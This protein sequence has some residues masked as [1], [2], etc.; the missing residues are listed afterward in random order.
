M[1]RGEAPKIRVL[2][3][4][5]LPA[6][7]LLVAVSVLWGVFA[8]DRPTHE[9]IT[10][11]VDR[12]DV[13]RRVAAS[14]KLRASNTIKVGAEVSGQIIRVNVDFD[15]AVIAGQVLAEID[16]TRL[17]ARVEQVRAQ[18][19]TSQAA[20]AQA[21]ALASRARTD[22]GLQ[23]REFGRRTA[24]AARGFVSASSLDAASGALAS[25]RVGARTA[26]TQVDSARAGIALA[27]AELRAA[28]LDLRRT[29]IVSPATGVVI[30][31]LV[32]PGTTVVASFQTPNLFEIATDTKRMQIEASVDEADIGQVRVGQPVQFTVDSYPDERFVTAVR[33]IRQAA[34][35]S[36]NVVSYLVILDVDNRDGRL[37]SGMTAD[38]EI[39]TGRKADVPRIPIS[40]LRFRPRKEDR[41][42]G[43]AL[44]PGQPAVYLATRD[45]LRPVRRLVRLGLTGDDFAEVAGGLKVGD[46]VL[47][48][49]RPVKPGKETDSEEDADDAA[50]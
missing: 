10:H 4:L 50:A 3:R 32:D 26:A 1:E 45:P 11:V 49:S 7:L 15:S 24:L 12:G 20:L 29:R 48:R 22:L 27:N 16:P 33:Q 2:R 40:A 46:A 9:Y 14:G 39:I 44:P 19:A 47:V 25:A 42:D 31:R 35:E 37:L 18:V 13:I 5:W 30:N 38:V 28:L 23:E 41:P 21:E 6:A 43:P 36:Q 17:R 8:A 34:T